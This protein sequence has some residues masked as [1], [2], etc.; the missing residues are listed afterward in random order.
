MKTL[1]I[2]ITGRVQKVGFRACA[3][4]IAID[5]KVNGTVMNLADGKVQ[6]F[7]TAEPIIL[8]K[9]ISMLY[10][11]PRAI[12]RDIKITDIMIRTYDEFSVIKND[13]RISTS[14]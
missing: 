14:L 13:G 10:G 1:E 2:I 12:I 11:C 9:F 4:K 5:L 3:R 7:A 8:E 6:I